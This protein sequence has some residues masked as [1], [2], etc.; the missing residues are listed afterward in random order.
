MGGDFRTHRL[1]INGNEVFLALRGE[2]QA[3]DDEEFLEVLRKTITSQRDFM[4]D[5][6][7][8]YYAVSII[9]IEQNQGSGYQG[10]GLTNSFA[11]SA[12]NNSYLE[13]DQLVYLLNHEHQHNWIGYL[14]KNANEE[15][16]YWFS[17][18]FTDY[19]TIKN[20]ARN[21]I[22]G[23]NAT[24]VINKMNDVIKELYT[25]P[26]KD[27]PNSAISY[28]NFWTD[29]NYNDLPYKRGSLFAFILDLKIQQESNGL[30]SLDDVILAIKKDAETSEQRISHPYIIETFEPYLK[31]FENFFR[32][33][34]EEGQ[35]FDLTSEF[36]ALGF[37]TV[38]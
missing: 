2:W 20:I 10:T 17:E 11:M 30:K 37:E 5:H 12:T 4:Q 25:S 1:P 26:V 13:L 35:L 7:Q 3:F 23:H 16:Q 24:Y 22:N 33:H 14:I 31:G 28:D 36:N 19:Y 8:S 32:R 21:Q 38:P 34:I 6:G 29:H 15:E 18:G 9:P 27:A